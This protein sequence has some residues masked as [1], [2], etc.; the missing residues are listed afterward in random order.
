MLQQ[1]IFPRIVFPHRVHQAENPGVHQILE[2]HLRRQPVVN[3]A[4][5]VMHL[6]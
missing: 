2:R 6:R 1:N 3:A 4:R 5:D